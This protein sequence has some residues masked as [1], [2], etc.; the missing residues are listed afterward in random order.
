MKVYGY[1]DRGLNR[2]E[3][4]H[5]LAVS[6]WWACEG[7]VSSAPTVSPPSLADSADIP[8]TRLHTRALQRKMSREFTVEELATF[9]GTGDKPVYL[10]VKGQVRPFGIRAQLG[11]ATEEKRT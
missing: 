6:H 1:L 7:V 5:R 9:D 4:H 3:H 11:A 2:P 8:D 10:A